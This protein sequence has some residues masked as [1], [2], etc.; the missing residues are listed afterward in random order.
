M[1][2]STVSEKPGPQSDERA[3]DTAR[4]NIYA[5]LSLAASDPRSDRW[6]NLCQPEFHEMAIE[7]AALLREHPSARPESLAPGELNP[8]ALDIQS[9][10]SFLGQGR[11]AINE[12]YESIFGLLPTKE[13]PLY[14]T[15]YCP[16]TFSVYRSQQMADIAGFYRAFGLQPSRDV[17]ERPDHLAI[18]LEFMAHLIAREQ[19]A[20]D[21]QRPEAVERAGVSRD[22]QRGFV[23][24][25]LAWWVPAFAFALRRASDGIEDLKQLTEP[26][27]SFFGVLGQCLSCFMAVERAVLGISPPTE[28]VQ[29]RVTTEPGAGDCDSCR[30][31]AAPVQIAF[32]S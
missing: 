15:E 21:S 3:L 28:L 23:G 20:Q 7:A 32:P 25:H 24:D 1:S 17:P 26:P 6:V 18:E 8:E 30:A 27:N 16:Q 9:L 12:Q 5:F 29:T 10:I 22:A 14:E 2:Q 19:R 31:E 13:C 11:E 4:Q